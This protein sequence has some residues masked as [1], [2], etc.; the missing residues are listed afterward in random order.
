MISNR[1]KSVP[2]SPF[3]KLLPLAD[4]AKANGVK[5]F[6]LNIGQPDIPTPQAAMEAL[7]DYPTSMVP[8]TPGW[9]ISQIERLRVRGKYLFFNFSPRESDAM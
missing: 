1:S 2:F 3:R 4:E 8:Y 7:S 5:I 9:Y 6:H